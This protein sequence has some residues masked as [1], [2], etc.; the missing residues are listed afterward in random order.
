MTLSMATAGSGFASNPLWYL[1]RTTGLITF[2]LLTAAVCLGVLSTQRVSTPRWPRFASQSLHRNISGM[3]VVF[4]LVHVLTTLLDTY[5][6]V[7][8]WAAIVPFTSAYK[9]VVVGYGTLA[10]DLLL[11]VSGT[12]LIRGVTGH[13]W[14]R[15]VHWSAYAAWPLALAH[16]LGTGTDARAPWSIALVGAS[17]VAVFAAVLFR[18]GSE[19]RQ[20]PTRVLGGPR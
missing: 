14:W 9:T 17:I 6:S 10:L 3:A 11:V 19:G 16:Y 7:S 4:L 20:G 1:T 12:S 8:W 15:L 5:V 18:L 13:R 2:V